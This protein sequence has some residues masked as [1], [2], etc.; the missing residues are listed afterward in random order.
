MLQRRMTDKW[1]IS[2]KYQSYTL[3]IELIKTVGLMKTVRNVGPFYPRLIQELIVNL[4]TDFNDP[5]SANFEKVL[6]I[7]ISISPTILNQF[8]GLIVPDG[9]VIKY[10][11]NEQLALK[12]FG[13]TVK[14]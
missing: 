8:L 14:F 7:C 13:G 3:V 11:S 4:S 10:P 1:N 6:G 9:L 5:T 12:L 2:T